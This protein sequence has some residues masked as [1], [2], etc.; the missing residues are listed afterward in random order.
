LKDYV[1]NALLETE[2]KDYNDEEE[3]SKV[4][5]EGSIAAET[6]Q[7]KAELKKALNSMVDGDDD[8]DD[9]DFLKVRKKSKDEEDEDE[10]KFKEFKLRADTKKNKEAAVDDMD[11]LTKFWQAK[12]EVDSKEKFLRSY[13]M[14]K[15]WLEK[16]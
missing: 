14:N 16:K 12:E 8:D 10:K 3:I 2:G 1:R 13:I 4:M 15:G 11:L 6:Y 5:V 7:A 9:D